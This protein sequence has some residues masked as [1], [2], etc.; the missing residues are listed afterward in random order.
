M[1]SIVR[2]FDN[3]RKAVD[4][5]TKATNLTPECRADIIGIKTYFQT[6]E[7]LIMASIWVKVLSAIHDTNLVIQYRDATLDVERDNM[8][9]LRENWPQIVNEAT[10]VAT[11]VQL[12][13]EF[14]KRRRGDSQ[15]EAK[16]NFK[17][18]VFY[19]IIDSIISGLTQRF[20]AVV[21]ICNRFDFLWCFK[22]IKE[23]ELKEKAAQFHKTYSRHVSPHIE[24]EILSL[25]SVYD[26]NFKAE[27][28]RPKE[29]YGEIHDMGLNALFPNV[30]TALRI[31]L[32]LPASVASNE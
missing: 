20:E 12:T 16:N 32:T 15:E 9:D 4:E 24:S 23:T 29:L 28:P 31:F 3:I 21:T 26:A 22:D 2:H 1:R 11:N 18:D 30:L 13:S 6:F 25:K 19:I 8:P 14:A 17:T 27:T 5:L 10:I 7:S